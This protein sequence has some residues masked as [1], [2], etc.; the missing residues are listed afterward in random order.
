MTVEVVSELRPR[1]FFQ[2]E[3]FRVLG[4]IFEMQCARHRKKNCLLVTTVTAGHTRSQRVT[5]CQW[6]KK[7]CLLVTTASMKHP[8]ALAPI[9]L[10]LGEHFPKSVFTSGCACGGL[11]GYLR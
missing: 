9:D 8:F 6:N 3:R 7:N 10:N 5:K 1:K 4:H 2:I 11:D